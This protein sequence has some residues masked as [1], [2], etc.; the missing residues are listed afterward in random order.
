MYFD[1]AGPRFVMNPIKIFAGSF[2]GATLWANPEYRSPNLVSQSLCL[3][4]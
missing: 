4:L 2:G 1:F 3:Q